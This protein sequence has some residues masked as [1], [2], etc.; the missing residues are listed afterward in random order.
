MAPATAAVGSAPTRNRWR[1]QLVVVLH[2]DAKIFPE[3][4]GS[5][6]QK[7]VKGSVVNDQD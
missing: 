6:N 2:L 5:L 1:K 4:M 7:P 3:I